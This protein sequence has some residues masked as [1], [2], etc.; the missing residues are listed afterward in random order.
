LSEENKR[1]DERMNTRKRKRGIGAALVPAVTTITTNVG[2]VDPRAWFEEAID[3]VPEAP[4]VSPHHLA[5]S[6]SSFVR[7]SHATVS[8]SRA[9]LERV[10]ELLSQHIAYRLEQLSASK[11]RT[12]LITMDPKTGRV[13]ERPGPQHCLFSPLPVNM[14]PHKSNDVMNE[15]VQDPLLA[16]LWESVAPVRVA[17]TTV[18]T[19]RQISNTW[20]SCDPNQVAVDT[21]WRQHCWEPSTRCATAVPSSWRFPRI[22]PR[23]PPDPG[24]TRSSTQPPPQPPLHPPPRHPCPQ[25]ET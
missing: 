12:P 4:P 3:D 2:R 25:P 20:A 19:D 10:S 17:A 22:S 16:F 14:H 9:F 18:Q 5:T 8:R 6:W 1:K 13:R 21:W 24:K 23:L 7:E 15:L 11:R